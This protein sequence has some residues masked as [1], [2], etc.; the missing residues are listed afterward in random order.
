MY[1]INNSIISHFH[2]LQVAYQLHVLEHFQFVHHLFPEHHL[3]MDHLAHHL[4]ML[5]LI[6]P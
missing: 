4:C 1:S 6:Q 2:Y 3:D 5:F